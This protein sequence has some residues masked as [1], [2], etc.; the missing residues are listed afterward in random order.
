ML[1]LRKLWSRRSDK[2]GQL[3]RQ[4]GEVAQ[5]NQILKE[6][7]AELENR[8]D[9]IPGV[10]PDDKQWSVIVGGELIE[11]KA[12]PPHE[13]LHSLEELPAFLYVFLAEKTA[14]PNEAP[15]SERLD[16]LVALAKRWIQ[17]C[18]VGEVNLD[19]LTLPEAEH[20]VAHIAMLNGVS[21]AL[22]R[23]FLEQGMGNPS[24]HRAEIRATPE[25]SPGDSLN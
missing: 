22:R 2:L 8:A 9:A 19:R 21:D 14:K 16:D 12:I 10:R 1:R 13:W 5:E 7:L 25:H 15:S 24:E 3:T 20:A 18:A 11:L 6:R 4:L 23:W 17:A